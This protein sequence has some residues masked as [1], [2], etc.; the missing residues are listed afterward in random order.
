MRYQPDLME[1]QFAKLVKKSYAIF[2]MTYLSGETCALVLEEV[3]EFF[4]VHQH[5][6]CNLLEINS[7]LDTERPQVEVEAVVPFQH[8]SEEVDYTTPPLIFSEAD[9]LWKIARPRSPST[10]ERP[11]TARAIRALQSVAR[12]LPISIK[13]ARGHMLDSPTVGAPGLELDC[14]ISLQTVDA[15]TEFLQAQPHTRDSSGAPTIQTNFVNYHSQ[16]IGVRLNLLPRIGTGNL[17]N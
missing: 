16:P 4:E 5:L 11:P 7:P 9:L 2:L 17:R 1:F 12:I 3:A 14:P 13:A 15:L 8:G 6:G 10:S